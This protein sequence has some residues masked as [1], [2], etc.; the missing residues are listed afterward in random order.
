[1]HS[2]IRGYFVNH[3]CRGVPA[4]A[5]TKHTAKMFNDLIAASAQAASRGWHQHA[6]VQEIDCALVTMRSGPAEPNFLGHKK[7]FGAQGVFIDFL[8]LSRQP[9]V[10]VVIV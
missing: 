5:F 4:K 2:D 3:H 7:I 10:L 1:M 9:S 6:Q 8:L